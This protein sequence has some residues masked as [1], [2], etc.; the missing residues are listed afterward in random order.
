MSVV[1]LG[2]RA[3][4]F[5]PRALVVGLGSALVALAL[6]VVAIGGG[7]FPMT[8]SQVVTALLG[9]GTPAER[10]IVVELRL[11]RAICALVVGA[12]L[13]LAGALFQTLVRNPLGSPDLLGITQGATVG[14]LA[15]VVAGG[16]TAALSAGALAGGLL[17]GAAIYLLAWKRGVH[18]FRLILIGIGATAILTGVN[19]Y[20]FTRAELMEAARALLWITGSLDGRGW[21][22]VLPLLAGVG[23]LVA[24]VLPGS[25]R[26]LRV[27]E[28]GDD[29]ASG[30][31]V[32]VERLRMLLLG[33]AVLLTS[34]A[35]A[36]AGPVNF[37]ALTAPQL[38][39]RLTRSPG[40]N[41]LASMCVGAAM[42][43][44]ADLVAQRAFGERQLPVGVITGVIGGGYLVWLLITERRAGR[45]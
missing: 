43:V 29:L 22:H 36:A 27:T 15:V 30:L 7:E 38:A 23:V 35:A 1:W 11:P 4:V 21:E 26:A 24:L 41:L 42:L 25:G 44:A 2:A 31:G 8:P 17:T 10:F 45:L 28:M 39:R 19:G 16:G 6:T 9:G 18:G 14:A 5:R 13:A 3:V 40:P 34:F 12:A 32:R 37:V 20:L 33:A